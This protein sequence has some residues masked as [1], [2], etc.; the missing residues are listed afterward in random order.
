VA[1]RVFGEPW[2][3]LWLLA[4]RRLKRRA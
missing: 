1:Y 2:V 3:L 4:A